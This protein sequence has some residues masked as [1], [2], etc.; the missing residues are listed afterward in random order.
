[1]NFFDQFDNHFLEGTIFRFLTEEDKTFLSHTCQRFYKLFREFAVV[2]PRHILYIRLYD[3]QSPLLEYEPVES[4]RRGHY[5]D[6]TEL[7]RLAIRQWNIDY[8]KKFPSPHKLGQEGCLLYAV[9]HGT[10]EIMEHLFSTCNSYCSGD[11]YNTRYI[12][13]ASEIGDLKK[14]QWLE[15]RKY[16]FPYTLTS[17]FW[18]D[19]VDIFVY[20]M[21]KLEVRYESNFLVSAIDCG[22]LELANYIYSHPDFDRRLLSDRRLFTVAMTSRRREAALNWLLSIGYQLDA[23]MVKNAIELNSIDAIEWLNV[24]GISPT[25]AHF[26]MAADRNRF[27][28]VKYLVERGHKIDFACVNQIFWPKMLIGVGLLSILYPHPKRIV[29]YTLPFWIL[30]RIGYHSVICGIGEAIGCCLG[31][32]TSIFVKQKKKLNCTKKKNIILKFNFSFFFFSFRIFSSKRK[33]LQKLD[34]TFFF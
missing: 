25:A 12:L 28:V 15:M 21:K 26:R 19:Y 4:L 24:H 7:S 34:H 30:L 22:S 32:L 17:F 10:I 18:C 11:Q 9:R 33:S 13:T 3:S 5:P 16:R 2:K 8:L 1:M 14:V 31:F 27:K 23:R 6:D 29:R 20:A